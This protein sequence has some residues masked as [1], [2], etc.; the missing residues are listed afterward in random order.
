MSRD[1]KFRFGVQLRGAR[2]AAEWRDKGRRAEDAGFAVASMP[3]HLSG[4]W[5]PLPALAAL[6]AATTRLRL[7]TWVLANDFRHPAILAK[8]AATLDVL[9]DGRL[10]LGI[11]AGWMTEDYAASGIA[12]DPARVRIERLGEALAVLRGL[13]GA[14]AFSFD[15]KHYRIRALDGQPKPLQQPLPLQ[16][17]G[18][19]PAILALAAQ[20]AQIVGLAMRLGA[21][22][23]DA[24]GGRSLT[25]AET[26][27]KL[28]WV[29]AAAGERF[30]QLE[31]SVRVTQTSFAPASA[32]AAAA[33]LGRPLGLAAEEI[34]ASPHALVG[35]AERVAD[36]LQRCRERWGVSYFVVSED[37]LEPFAPVVARLG[38]R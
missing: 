9:S 20:Q 27:R 34:L 15:G 1:R 19:G 12:R 4:Q 36:H 23:I 2:S 10:E 32:I 28:G 22:A 17:G 7:S 13:W 31:L 37:A 5:A 8:E 29:R 38:G 6:A 33:E 18:G 35:D 25:A 14:G 21:G 16:I 30:E 11:G 24:R 26:D 3:D